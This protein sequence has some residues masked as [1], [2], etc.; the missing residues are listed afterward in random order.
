M[1]LIVTIFALVFITELVSWIG[2]SVLQQLVLFFPRVRDFY[3]DLTRPLHTGMD[4]VST[5][6]QP[7]CPET[8]AR[9]QVG[10]PIEKG[11]TPADQCAGPIRKM[12]KTS[13]KRR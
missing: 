3:D 2:K 12:G 9:A 10:A 1:S 8:S 7:V 6:L 13:S 4:S 5:T 11:R